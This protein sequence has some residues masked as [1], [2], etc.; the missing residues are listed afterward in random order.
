MNQG[1]KGAKAKG[2]HNLQ[3]TIFKLL[4][5][6]PD[7]NAVVK[8]RKNVALQ[9]QQQKYNVES[10]QFFALLYKSAENLL[11]ITDVSSDMA[12]DYI[13]NNYNN[14]INNIP[15]V[16]SAIVSKSALK[17]WQ[18]AGQSKSKYH[19]AMRQG[20]GLGLW[21]LS[22]LHKNIKQFK[23]INRYWHRSMCKLFQCYVENLD[24]DKRDDST[25]ETDDAGSLKRTS[26]EGNQRNALNNKLVTTEQA[27][28]S[29]NFGVPTSDVHP[30]PKT[31]IRDRSK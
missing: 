9:I 2:T 3:Y 20:V 18:H 23:H 12:V 10:L 21:H 24:A 14:V 7:N 1:G 25:I 31:Y 16:A 19:E 13:L 8:S 11:Q 28:K 4:S 5:M 15:N 17:F 30:S 27:V 26:N 29:S 6:D 22:N